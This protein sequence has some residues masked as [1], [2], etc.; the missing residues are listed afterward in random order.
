MELSKDIVHAYG[1][2]LLEHA[3]PQAAAPVMEIFPEFPDIIYK[4]VYYYWNAITQDADD[5]KFFDIA[6][7]AN[8]DYLVTI[9]AHFNEAKELSF[10]TSLL[11]HSTNFWICCISY[12]SISRR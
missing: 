1:E 5:N 3:A 6:I 10:P 11:Y 8:A 7:A 4:R 2:I 9:D 12:N